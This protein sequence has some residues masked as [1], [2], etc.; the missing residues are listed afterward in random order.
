MIPARIYTAL[1]VG[2]KE[3]QDFFRDPRSIVLTLVLPVVLFP[4]LFWVLA[5]RR[6][7]RP[8]DGRVFTIALAGEDPDFLRRTDPGYFVHVLPDS[9][10]AESEAER[11]KLLFGSFDAVIH[12]KGDAGHK[13]PIVYFNNADSNSAAAVSYLQH[14]PQ[15]TEGRTQQQ[16]E[17]AQFQTA[18]IYAS[19][20]AAGK[21]FLALV[22]P[23]MIFIFA[24]TCPLPVAAD[25]SA[26][27]KE[28]F[29]LEPLLSTAA[30]RSGIAAGKLLAAAC[31]GCISVGAYFI[32]VYV[33]VLISPEI[34]GEQAM[35]FS[36]DASQ[37]F[38]TGTLIVLATAFFAALE[39][40]AGF[41]AR[42]VR[43]AQLLGMPL[44]FV[45]M[46]AVY[47][48]Q[49]VD[50]KHVP[51]IFPHLPLVNL[52]LVIRE[53]ALD[54]IDPSHAAFTIAWSIAYLFC[55]ALASVHRFKHESVIGGS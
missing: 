47:V 50:L 20:V 30:P 18:P 22:L 25:L 11:R 49:S 7:E 34:V 28:R 31:A 53:A 10:I 23:F 38:I 29:S 40:T 41:M 45:S 44:L 15:K 21:M 13:T 9:S 48:A 1:I 43:E 51:A 37:F 24:A 17:P 4:L 33:S 19:E 6:P 8:A 3:L 46:G 5:E 12:Y 14:S 36:F 27:E 54:R 52:G 2:R 42:S 32:G 55:A 16:Q 35:V 26:G 39:L